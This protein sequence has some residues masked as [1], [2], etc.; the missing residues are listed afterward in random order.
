MV[1]PNYLDQNHPLKGTRVLATLKTDS[2][3]RTQ[4]VTGDLISLDN[5]HWDKDLSEYQYLSP[6][7]RHSREK[8]LKIKTNNEF[9]ETF[10]MIVPLFNKFDWSNVILAG[11]SVSDVLL[12]DCNLDG[13]L[14]LFV[15]GL[16]E[17][18]AS[19]RVKN[20]VSHFLELCKNQ[21]EYQINV[22]VK[23]ENLLSIYIHKLNAKKQLG[24]KRLYE[25]QII[26][27]LY[28]TISEVLHGFDLGSSAVGFDGAK[29]YFTTL[30]QYSYANM[31]N[32]IDSTRRSTSYEYRLQ[33]YLNRGFNI[34]MPD[35]RKVETIEAI[36]N[37]HSYSNKY[38][39]I[40]DK[41][42]IYLNISLSVNPNE[43]AIRLFDYSKPTTRTSKIVSEFLSPYNSFNHNR[44]VLA[45]N[46]WLINAIQR[47]HAHLVKEIPDYKHMSI[48][49][50]LYR[51]GKLALLSYIEKGETPQNSL[52]IDQW[53]TERLERIDAYLSFMREHFFI[54]DWKTQDPATQLTSSFNP[55]IA[56]SREWY[57][58]LHW[59][60]DDDNRVN[61]DITDMQEDDNVDFEVIPGQVNEI[62]DEFI[63]DYKYASS[64]SLLDYLFG[65]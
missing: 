30:S 10:S 7:R 13:D 34:I 11:G 57:G 35:L 65:T 20:I 2:Q 28:R 43:H 9:R 41:G 60:Y 59:S 29:V 44:L 16:D 52:L 38:L 49:K 32:I 26:F 42:N 45:S 50:W 46:S 6:T 5:C 48:N 39:Y 24:E 37:G 64:S 14:D 40:S 56:D 61:I 1:I 19:A 63:D 31:V 25:I 47:E 53:K 36:M 58:L 55:I 17:K 54:I 62:E 15:Y 12:G 3:Y 22:M 4:G 23:T 18:D 21:P 51:F 27:R 33:K 8:S